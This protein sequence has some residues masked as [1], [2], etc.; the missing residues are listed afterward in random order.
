MAFANQIDDEEENV[1]GQPGLIGGETSVIS[2][3]GTTQQG[4]APTPVSANPAQKGGG[5]A[6][7]SNFV[8]IQQ[9]IDQNKPQSAKLANQVGGFVENLSENAKN[10]LGQSETQYNQ[11]VDQNIVNYNSDL[12]NEVKS[13]A[14]QVAADQAKKDEVTKQ[15]TATYQGPTSFLESQYY[16][17]TQEAVKKAQQATEQTTTEEG[18]KQLLGQFQGKDKINQGALSFDSALLQSDPTSRTRLEQ[19]RQSSADLGTNLQNLVSTGATK[20]QQAAAA[21]QATQQQANQVLGTQWQALK[22]ALTGKTTAAQ[23]GY[24]SAQEVAAGN[25]SDRQLAN[26]GLSRADYEKI[27]NDPYIDKTNL[28]NYVASKTS[29]AMINQSNVADAEDY[30]REQALIDLMGSDEDLI[31]TPEAAGTGNL[32]SSPFEL[33]RLKQRQLAEATQRLKMFEATSPYGHALILGRQKTPAQL[34]WDA[35]RNKYIQELEDY[36]AWNG[37]PGLKYGRDF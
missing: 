30:A 31:N 3:Q 26:I 33:D 21:T 23:Q 11:A 27:L 17:P 5:S 12:F 36:Y 22:D 6:P 32:K 7:G 16:N 14:T 19:A 10:Q 34:A 15:R 13:N 29:G 20:A 2:G 37:Q 25:L 35:Q 28:S 8:G 4:G 9:Y 18:Q 1:E 24:T